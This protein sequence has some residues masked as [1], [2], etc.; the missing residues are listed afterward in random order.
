MGLLLRRIWLALTAV[1]AIVLAT[2]SI[3]TV[4]QHDAILSNLIRQRLSVVVGSTAAPF[5]SVVDLGLPVSMMRNATELLLRA[6]ET[7]PLIKAVH[8]INPSGIVV[9]STLAGDVEPM[10]REIVRALVDSANGRWTAETD[11]DLISGYSILDEGGSPVAGVV[12]SYPRIEL[13]SRSWAIRQ[14]MGLVSAV[15]LVLFSVVSYLALRVRMHGPIGELRRIEKQLDGSDEQASAA[16]SFPE[17]SEMLER[18]SLAYRSALS[19][20]AKFGPPAPDALPGNDAAASVRFVGIAETDL[21]RN[22]ARRLMP[23]VA[24]MVFGSALALAYVAYLGIDESFSPEIAKRTELIGTVANAN[25]QRAIEAGVPLDQLVGGQDYFQDLTQNLPEI[26]YLGI[27]PGKPILEIGKKRSASEGV[28]EFPLLLDGETIGTIVTET[29]PLYFAAQFRDMLLDLS[30]VLLVIVLFAFEL[31]VVMMASS[32][33]L[34]IDGLQ[35]VAGLQAASDFSKRLA[36]SG[37]NVIGRLTN[38]ISE[39]AVRLNGMFAE[40]WRSALAGQNPEERERLLESLGRRF[41]LSRSGAEVLRFCSLSDV[42][43][44]LFLFA[45]ADELPLSFFSLYAR[46]ADNPITWIS[47]GIVIGLPLAAYLLATL[48]GAP[49]ARPLERRFGYRNLFLAGAGMCMLANVGLFAAG[50][51]VHLIA[52]LALNGLGFVL[53]SL[54]CQDYVLDMLPPAVRSRS[55]GL[56]RTAMFSGVFAGTALGGII[57]D[58]MGQRA[59]FIVCAVVMAVSAALIWHYVPQ[60]RAGIR[61]T[62]EQEDTRFSFNLLAPMRSARF[63]ATAFGIIVPLEIVNHV[64]VS[65]LL[66]LQMDALGSSAAGIGRAMMCFFLMLIIGGAVHDKVPQRYSNP[67]L[68]AFASSVVSGA[69][70]LVAAAF[71]SS[72]SMFLAAAGT[73]LGLGLSGGPQAVLVMD[74]AEGRLSHLGSSVVLGTTRLLERGGAVAGLVLTGLL[75]GYIGYSGAVGAIGCLVLFGAVVFA[76][77]HT[78]GR[79]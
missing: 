56:I 36:A 68:V 17:F 78:V 37:M 29:D 58:R 26:S 27:L 76:L 69:V 49:L 33:T 2:L 3:L 53:A 22:I 57:A 38:R 7:D 35:H 40:A 63:A 16:A 51:I 9:D 75:T 15:L 4:L 71:P 45:M 65:Y 61:Q 72:A 59:V 21:A 43:L 12:A 31:V 74:L 6:R 73:G 20:L 5:R 70:L 1:M 19:E 52:C 13:E 62:G 50:N 47:P 64:F 48:F 79:N 39:R 8:L 30:V 25:I 34:P 66:S 67:A 18:A 55:I 60:F 14:R 23:L 41:G 11:T 44:P 28:S 10:P 42:R 32:V 46:D 24:A 77:L 54:S